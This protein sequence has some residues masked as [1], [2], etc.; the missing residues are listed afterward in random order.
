MRMGKISIML[1]VLA[2]TVFACRVSAQ[3]NQ[4]EESKQK[5][6]GGQEESPPADS[7]IPVDEMPAPITQVQPK[8]PETAAKAKLEGTVWLKLLVNKL[9]K[10]DSVIVLRPSA[11]LAELE[12]AAVDAAKQWV[13]KPATQKGIPV[14]VWAAIQ[15]KFKLSSSKK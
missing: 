15:V 9:G 8:Y 10:I 12:R 4:S 14:A 1:M 7:F 5:G 3:S 2:L 6:T 13:F 11:T